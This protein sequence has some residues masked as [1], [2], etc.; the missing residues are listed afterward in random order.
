VDPSSPI[1]FH[2]SLT[3]ALKHRTP[4]NRKSEQKAISRS[5]MD[6]RMWEES[7]GGYNENAH[8]IT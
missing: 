5:K 6:G 2:I 3:E 4:G 7:T 8:Q 1:R